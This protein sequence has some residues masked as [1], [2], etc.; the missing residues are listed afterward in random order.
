MSRHGK[1]RPR[2]STAVSNGIGP[3]PRIAVG[4][5]AE[6][7]AHSQR[8]DSSTPMRLSVKSL[9]DWLELR[10]LTLP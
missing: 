10:S 2:R 1:N 9:K 6:A 7:G 4:M 5:A 3:A 8:Y